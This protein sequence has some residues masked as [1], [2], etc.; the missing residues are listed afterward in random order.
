M[1]NI[2]NTAA[3]HTVSVTIP[4]DPGAKTSLLQ[5][6]YC[7]GGGGVNRSVLA[8]TNRRDRV[9][10]DSGSATNELHVRTEIS[11]R[12]SSQLAFSRR[13]R[14]VRHVRPVCRLSLVAEENDFN[15]NNMYPV[16]RSVAIIYKQEYGSTHDRQSP[17]RR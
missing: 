7:T 3:R 16:T 10:L 14:R 4:V 2:V 17:S 9:S 13:R 15:I 12:V 1:K 5:S 11:Q 8:M 6:V